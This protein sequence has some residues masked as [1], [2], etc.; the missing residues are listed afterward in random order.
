MNV[1]TLFIS[2]TQPPLIKKPI[3]G[4]FNDIAEFSK[5]AS[6]FGVTFGDQRY[7]VTLPQWATNFCFRI[8]GTIRQYFIGSSSWSASWLFDGRNAINQGNR[9][10]RVMHVGAGMFN[11][12]RCPLT[13]YNQMTFRA[14]FASIC[15]VWASFRPP[16]SARTEQLSMADVDQSIASDKPNSSSKAPH[17]FCQTPSFCQSRKR[18]Q[19]VIPQPHCISL[20]RY[21]QG[22]PVLSTNKMP[23]RQARSSIRGR[24]PLGLGGTK[25]MCGLMR[26]HSSLVSSGLAIVASSITSVYGLQTNV[27]SDSASRNL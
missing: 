20:G 2:N 19:Q 10:F 27:I 16:K 25:G 6:V 23:V 24:P 7:Y 17:T 18:R 22:V 5:A 12:K 4:S 26:S 21:S 15:G 8:V 11:R 1:V 9:H 14:V 3:K 13:I